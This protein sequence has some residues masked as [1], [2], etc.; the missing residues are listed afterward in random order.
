MDD[1]AAKIGMSRTSLTWRVG[2]TI[3]GAVA[4][5]SRFAAR[6][7]RALH[8]ERRSGAI[9][10]EIGGGC[11]L[12]FA[13]AWCAG[14]RGEWGGDLG[15]GERRCTTISVWIREKEKPPNNTG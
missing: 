15:R 8:G 3:W 7:P 14:E 10:E 1:G 9:R 4:G 11:W 2:A 6:P 12:G 5:Y 13:A